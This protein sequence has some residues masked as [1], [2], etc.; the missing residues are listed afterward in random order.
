MAAR[1]RATGMANKARPRGKGRHRAKEG[2]PEA[3]R[4]LG[5]GALTLGIGAALAGG[6]GT[7]HADAAEGAASHS[8]PS[9]PGRTHEKAGPTSDSTSAQSGS[10]RPRTGHRS[11]D[12]DGGEDSASASGRTSNRSSTG[13]EAHSGTNR[14]HP[15]TSSNSSTGAS[16]ADAGKPK[17]PTPTPGEVTTKPL[18]VT[19]GTK[20]SSADAAPTPSRDSLSG[21][22]TPSAD[23]PRSVPTT[24]TAPPSLPALIFAAFLPAAGTAN[25]TVHPDLKQSTSQV[26]ASPSAKTL[27]TTNLALA[28]PQ[29]LAP[30]ALGLPVLGL[31]GLLSGVLSGL[32][33]LTGGLPLLGPIVG[34]VVGVVSSTTEVITG[35][36]AILFGA[37]IQGFLTAGEGISSAIANAALLVGAYPIAIPAEF[38]VVGFQVAE[39]GVAF[40]GI[41]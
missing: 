40:F 33:G 35:A 20:K 36:A 39:E 9:S 8:T 29:V 12:K 27:L 16:D 25:S 6:T 31:G 22:T 4:W 21:L 23:P 11:P 24:P 32:G 15:A 17:D 19:E 34:P 5:A 28:S 14:H 10:S 37:P 18:G 2:P 13:D 41:A 26:A 3:Y 1:H 30:A 38:F 7:A